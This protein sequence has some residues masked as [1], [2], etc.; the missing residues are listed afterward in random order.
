LGQTGPTP[1][2]MLY[3]EL[4]R[5]VRST[6]WK[7]AAA[8]AL[9][10]VPVAAEPEPTAVARFP[11]AATPPADAIRTT[12]ERVPAEKVSWATRSAQYWCAK[13]QRHEQHHGL[14]RALEAY[15]H[16][17]RADAT[18]G[19]AYLAMARLRERLGDV[20]E[21]E[22]IYTHATRLPAFESEALA[23]RA[24]LR[25]QQ[26]RR[27]EALR[28][29]QAAVETGDVTTDRLGLLAQWYVEQRNWA[30]SLAVHRRIEARLRGAGQPERAAQ[31]H[32][33]VQALVMLAGETDP[34]TSG[35]DYT[36]WVRRSLAEISR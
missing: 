9:V 32:V 29:L 15:S 5:A 3:V 10:T 31:V 7:V 28:D 21:A 36:D 6:G 1:A 11:D 23:H 18:F 4:V 8:L 12:S 16:A 27:E 14:L 13:A 25:R 35:L 19:P 33:Q 2:G 30:A 17:I 34:V 24:A 26:G 20:Q 22:R